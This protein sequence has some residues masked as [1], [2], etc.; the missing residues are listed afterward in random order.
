MS[1]KDKIAI[2]TD[3]TADIPRK[4]VN[5]LRIHVIPAILII[6]GK[7][8]EDGK[9]ISR[10]EFYE[11]LP[12][13]SHL[14]TTATPPIVSFQNTYRSL[15][16]EGYERIISIHVSKLLSGIY[17]TALLAVR[18]FGDKV[19]V[20]DSDQISLGL[21][22][23]VIS[24]A[25]KALK[26]VQPSH[27]IDSL[28][29]LKKHIKVFAMLDTLEFL[30]RSG[31]VSWA[32]ARIGSMLKIKPFIE[33]RKGIVYNVGQSR[34]RKK[35]IEHLKSILDNLGPLEKL[36]IL[37]SNAEGDANN[38]YSSVADFVQHEP[39][40]VNVTTIIGTHVGPNGIGFAA[41]LKNPN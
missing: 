22:F 13:I 18:S 28:F 36:A 38:F 8:Y 10:R 34:T 5:D 17:N 21:G 19:T 39:F 2:V 37:H 14:P 35:G 20:I 16:Q 24:A 11:R 41:V 6:D 25:E 1:L 15:F 26:G 32:K 12:T 40:I 23:Q 31:R 29:K 9:G 7:D 33:L 30:R 27:I 3:S 4:I